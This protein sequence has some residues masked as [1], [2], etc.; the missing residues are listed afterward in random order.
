M[1]STSNVLHL[2]H[3]HLRAQA[4]RRKVTSTLLKHYYRQ[5]ERPSA[6]LQPAEGSWGFE[7]YRAPREG[8]SGEESEVDSDGN[9]A[10]GEG[11]SISMS[12]RGDVALLK[13]GTL[14]MCYEVCDGISTRPPTARQRQ[15][16]YTAP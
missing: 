10:E 7:Q 6:D 16:A 14:E 8:S 15:W 2:Y 11:G 5:T 13:C 4:Q 12:V 1:S 9:G 3:L